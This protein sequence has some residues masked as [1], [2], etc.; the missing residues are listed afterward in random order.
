MFGET[1]VNPRASG[2]N[3]LKAGKRQFPSIRKV[4][5]AIN[6][7]A[8]LNTKFT[9]GYFFISMHYLSLLEKD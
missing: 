1:I 7:R 5:L 8:L 4:S 9:E 6:F 2:K 3:S